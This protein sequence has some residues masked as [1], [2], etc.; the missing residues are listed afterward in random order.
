MKAS[1]KEPEPALMPTAHNWLRIMGA[2]VTI[3]LICA[4]WTFWG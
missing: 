2:A 3:V 4:V 1:D